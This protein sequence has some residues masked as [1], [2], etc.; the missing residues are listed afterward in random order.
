[1]R[2]ACT[3]YPATA[4]SC[5]KNEMMGPAN[6]KKITDIV[7]PKDFQPE[8]EVIYQP[9]E[10]LHAAIPNHRGDWYFSGD[11]PTPGGNRVVNRA[12]VNYMQNKNVRAY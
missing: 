6:S 12:F 2:M 11:Y 7:R 3:A 5:V 8:L 9:I 4:A 1:M 10:G